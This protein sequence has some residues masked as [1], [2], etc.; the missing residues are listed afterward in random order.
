M[1]DLKV[2]FPTGFF[3]EEIRCGYTVT[4]QTKELWAVQID[5]LFQLMNVCEK[6]NISYFAID[7]TLLGAVRHKGFIPWD[8]DVDIGMFRKDYNRLCEIANKEFQYPYFFQT[9]YTDEGTLRGHAQLRNTKTTA[10]LSSEGKD[11]PFNQG[12]FID[13][14]PMDYVV[15]NRNKLLKQ[16]YKAI[17]YNKMARYLTVN[18]TSYHS[19]EAYSNFFIKKIFKLLKPFIRKI[20]LG[21]YFYYKFEQTCQQYNKTLST[22]ISALS[23]ATPKNFDKKWFGDIN[24]YNNVLYIPF[25]FFEI[26]A[27]TEYG[28]ILKQKYGDYLKFVIGENLHGE[29]IIDTNTSYM[30]Y[31]CNLK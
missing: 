23:F 20:N 5:L 6:Y 2:D 28:K 1:I 29:M 25:E 14:F 17:F 3:D 18:S 7:G 12:I 11:F 10:I 13:I 4:K 15:E 22:K 30:D 24:W 27:P 31:L 26:P 21:N 19:K 16:K 8:D 9:N